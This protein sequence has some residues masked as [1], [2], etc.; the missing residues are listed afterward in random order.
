MTDKQLA[1]LEHRR[2]ILDRRRERKEDRQEHKINKRMEKSNYPRFVHFKGNVLRRRTSSEGDFINYWC[3]N[4]EWGIGAYLE[5]RTVG[6]PRLVSRRDDMFK[7]NVTL[8]EA[9]EEEWVNAVGR[10]RPSNIKLLDG[11]VCFGKYIP[12][13]VN[14]G[15]FSNPC[16]EIALG[17]PQAC[18]LKY[19]HEIENKYRYLLIC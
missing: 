12:N 15:E 5:L 2:N 4:G 17:E 16:G 19:E 3:D 6:K 18:S 14:V 11:S 8:Y 10:Y 13:K 7:D 1:R 9:T